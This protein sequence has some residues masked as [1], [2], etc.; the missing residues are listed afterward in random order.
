MK[1][2]ARWREWASNL[3]PQ[4]L[5]DLHDGIKTDLLVF[6][7]ITEADQFLLK[8]TTQELEMRYGK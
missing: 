3:S 6:G 1:I 8:L 5:R 2:T 4:R 7:A